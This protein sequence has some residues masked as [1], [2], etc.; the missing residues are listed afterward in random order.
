M[1]VILRL[2]RSISSPKPF[3]R[4]VVYLIM[5]K[6]NNE[7]PIPKWLRYFLLFVAIIYLVWILFLKKGQPREDIPFFRP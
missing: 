7:S 5:A 3:L 6:L 2:Q 4:N 1:V